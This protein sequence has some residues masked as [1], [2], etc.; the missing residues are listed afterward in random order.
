MAKKLLF[1]KSVNFISC[2]DPNNFLYILCLMALF[3]LSKLVS[4]TFLTVLDFF[5]HLFLRNYFVPK[6]YIIGHKTDKN[7]TRYAK[8]GYMVQNMILFHWITTFSQMYILRPIMAKYVIFSSKK[9]ENVLFGGK[10]FFGK[11]QTYFA[12]HIQFWHLC[13]IFCSFY[14]Q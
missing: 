12:S 14:S 5:L 6:K 3:P 8:I 9:S 10:L 13:W 7:S 4:T 11:K 1:C 2:N